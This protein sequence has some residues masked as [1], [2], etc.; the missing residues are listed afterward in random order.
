MVLNIFQLFFFLKKNQF[1]KCP[2]F[3]LLQDDYIYMY[4][5]DCDIN[6]YNLTRKY[7]IEARVRQVFTGGHVQFPSNRKGFQYPQ[8][9]SSM[10]LDKTS[11]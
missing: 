6:T 4:I 9:F 10:I 3:Y 1:W 11:I 5:Y 8:P 2:I 7:V